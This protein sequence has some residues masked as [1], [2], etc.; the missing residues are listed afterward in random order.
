MSWWYNTVNIKSIN[1]ISLFENKKIKLHEDT[2][3]DLI[4][5]QTKTKVNKKV[6]YTVGII[7]VIGGICFTLWYFDVFNSNNNPGPG[8]RPGRGGTGNYVRNLGESSFSSNSSNIEGI[9]QINITDRQTR[10]IPPVNDAVA[11]MNSRMQSF[12][13][14]SSSSSSYNRYSV[15]DQLDQ[16]NRN[17]NSSIINENRPDSPTGSTD[18]SET[19]R[20][21]RSKGKS[22][23]RRVSK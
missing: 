8:S 4:E 2:P 5:D 22:L 12:N 17:N 20:P 16:E 3:T 19:I 13:D 7:V 10:T 1:S 18:S 11:E 14:S 15:L 23:L 21:S 9:H 6:W